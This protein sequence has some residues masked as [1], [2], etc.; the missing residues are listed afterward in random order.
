MDGGDGIGEDSEALLWRLIEERTRA[1][2]DVQAIDKSLWDRFGET[3]AVMFTDLSGFSRHVAAFGI[4]H[5]LQVIHEQKRLLLP[6]AA[7]HEGTLVKTCADSFLLLFRGV[8]SALRAA[9]AMQQA[10]QQYNVGRLPEQQLL[11]CVGVG[12]GRVLRIGDHEVFGQEVNAASKLGEDT[13][14]ADEVLVTLAARDAAGEVPGLSF[15]ELGFEV[16]GSDRNYRLDYPM[17]GAGPEK[18][19]T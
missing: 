9:V 7:E 5:F 14:K 18:E 8:D 13:A 19:P 10:C 4:V 12:Y 15:H 11:L 17:H 16:P 2:A 1:G 3:S 6:L